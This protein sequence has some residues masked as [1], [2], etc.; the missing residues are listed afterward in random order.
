MTSD[1]LIL[2][3]DSRHGQY[4]PQLFINECLH[5]NWN[6]ENVDIETLQN[7][8]NDGYWDEWE[9]VLN[10]AYYVDKNGVKWS[11]YQDGD[12]WAIAYDLMTK[13]DYLE[14]FGEYYEN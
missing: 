9:I 8:D 14:F 2:L 3:F 6:L 4:I 13:N 1:K 10:N 5:N 7:P 11:L 12:L